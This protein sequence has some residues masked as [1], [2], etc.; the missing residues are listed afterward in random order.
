[1]AVGNQ[2]EKPRFFI[3]LLNYN[4]HIGNILGLGFHDASSSDPGVATRLIGFQPYNKYM[5]PSTIEQWKSIVIRFKDPISIPK[6]DMFISCLAHDFAKFNHQFQIGFLPVQEGY[7]AG[8]AGDSVD[9]INKWETLEDICN[10]TGGSYIGIPEFN[11]WSISKFTPGE[12]EETVQERIGGIRILIRNGNFNEDSPSYWGWHLGGIGIGMIYEPEF[13]ADLAVTQRR[14]MDGVKQKQT[15]GGSTYS[16]INH[17]KPP[18]WWNSTPFELYPANQ[19]GFKYKNSRL[20]RRSWDVRFSQLQD[21]FYTDGV[22]NGVFPANELVGTHEAD[23]VNGGYS[24]DKDYDSETGDF[25]YNINNDNSLYGTVYHNTL[26]GT[27]PFLFSP[28]QDNSPGNFAICRF[29][30]PGFQVQQKT[31]KKFNVNMRINETW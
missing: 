29:D 13:H 31:Y 22:P 30:K 27:L 20:G 11:G 15:K 9:Y 7:E 16:V 12:T 1:M 18:N 21:R 10:S 25:N 8:L 19:T 26:N 4:Y 14:I 6:S 3:D 2:A 17:I 28:S 23:T 5:S 24:S